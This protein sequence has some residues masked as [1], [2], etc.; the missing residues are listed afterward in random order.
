MV[1]MARLLLRLSFLSTVLRS[2]QIVKGHTVVNFRAFS[3][4]ARAVYSLDFQ[5]TSDDLTPNKNKRPYSFYTGDNFEALEV[6]VTTV[7]TAERVQWHENK[8][9]HMGFVYQI[10]TCTIFCGWVAYQRRNKAAFELTVCT[11]S[12]NCYAG[13]PNMAGVCAD[14][15]PIC[16]VSVST[17]NP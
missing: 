8:L 7:G 5:A 16:Q 4:Q 2:H 15:T 10:L 13:A 9:F 12:A 6:Y 1:M 17:N 3:I 14:D 11:D